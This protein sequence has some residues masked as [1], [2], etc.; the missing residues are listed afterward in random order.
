MFTREEQC[1]NNHKQS[2][3]TTIMKL[4]LLEIE[5]HFF[6]NVAETGVLAIKKIRIVFDTRDFPT[7]DETRIS[8]AFFSFL[9]LS[10][11]LF[12]NRFTRK[13][14]CQCHSCSDISARIFCI[15]LDVAKKGIYGLRHREEFN[16]NE[17]QGIRV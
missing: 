11:S 14:A 15:F 17:P 7:E 2:R 9:Q 16:G 5:I 10:P 13:S 6:R 3:S 1:E 12:W 4:L 8:P